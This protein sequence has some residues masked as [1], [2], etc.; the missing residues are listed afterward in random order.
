MVVLLMTR[1]EVCG[2]GT[3]R[4]QLTAR[5]VAWAAL[6]MRLWS[7]PPRVSARPHRSPPMTEPAL[8][9]TAALSRLS[10]L[11]VSIHLSLLSATVLT[12]LSNCQVL[13]VR[14]FISTT[15][16]RTVPRL[17]MRALCF[18][19]HGRDPLSTKQSVMPAI[20]TTPSMVGRHCPLPG[21]SSP[22]LEP[23]SPC[24][25]HYRTRNRTNPLRMW[26]R[27]LLLRS[28]RLPYQR[29]GH[30]VCSNGKPLLID[31]PT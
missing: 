24:H 15:T 20:L 14:I 26:W 27:L 18:F 7:L 13:I 31:K 21:A 8:F 4:P 29:L 6:L 17:T 3:L 23:L 16:V 10:Q 28:S 30:V 9:N 2:V 25:C 1:L 12:K 5:R 19:C 11:V 22:G